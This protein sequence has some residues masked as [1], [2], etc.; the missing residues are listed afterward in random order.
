MPFW[1]PKRHVLA[2]GMPRFSLRNG[3]FC[4]AISRVLKSGGVGG[5]FSFIYLICRSALFPDA[6]LRHRRLPCPLLVVCFRLPFVA[7]AIFQ[8]VNPCLT[9]AKT[10][11]ENPRQPVVQA[12]TNVALI[13]RFRFRGCGRR[14]VVSRNFPI[15]AVVAG[16]N[17]PPAPWGWT[18]RIF[19][20]FLRPLKLNIRKSTRYSPFY[21]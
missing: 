17:F 11:R 9:T 3:A 2:C 18:L 15:H 5:A 1:S 19:D 10:L 16:C 14:K 4:S 12:T 21:N 8:P 7:V 20:V 13:R 6:M